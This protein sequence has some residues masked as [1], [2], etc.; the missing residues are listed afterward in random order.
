M[1]FKGRGRSLNGCS[2]PGDSEVKG[3]GDGFRT[4]FDLSRRPLQR[5]KT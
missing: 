5:A 3:S 2:G 1:G 4:P